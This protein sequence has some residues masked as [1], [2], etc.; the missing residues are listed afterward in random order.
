MHVLLIDIKLGATDLS[1]GDFT[2]VPAR[3][4]MQRPVLASQTFT[5]WSKDPVMTFRPG[6]QSSN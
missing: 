6:Y 4:W 5:V 1:A 2:I 3:V